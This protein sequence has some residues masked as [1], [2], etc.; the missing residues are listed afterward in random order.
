MSGTQYQ[1]AK[2]DAA[3]IMREKQRKGMVGDLMALLAY[4]NFFFT[5]A[6]ERKAAEAA[7]GKK[8]WHDAS[9]PLNGLYFASRNRK[10]DLRN[11]FSV[12]DPIRELETNLGGSTVVVFSMMQKWLIDYELVEIGGLGMSSTSIFQFFDIVPR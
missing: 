5:V 8:K 6:D 11:E 1:K 3:S 7:A 2:E 9:I 4:S 12:S 10:S